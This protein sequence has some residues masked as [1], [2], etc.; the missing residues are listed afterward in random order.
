MIFEK[1]KIQIET[2]SEYLHSVRENLGLPLEEVGKKTGIKL[3]FLQSLESGDFKVLPAEVYVYGFLRQLSQLYS[4]RSQELIDQYKKEKGIEH[5]RVK[6]ALESRT[7]FKKYFGKLVVTPK[8]LTLVLGLVFVAATAGYI[9][10]QVWSI[11]KTPSLQ[12]FEPANNQAVQASS[13]VVRGQ[14]DPG[15]AVTVNGQNIFVDN[16]GGFKTQLALS[17]GPEEITIMAQNH[18]GKSASQTINIIGSASSQATSTPVVLKVDFT[19]PVVLGFII[20]DQPAQTLSFGN[21]DSKTFSASRRILLSTSD[22][23]ATKVTLNGQAL[24]AMGKA[25][26]SLTD[27]PFFAP[28]N[29]A[30]N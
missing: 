17:Q 1:K 30:P 20:D 8:I 15:M 5:Q 14:T 23:G 6:Q 2:L 24:G 28:P 10:W 16:G 26:E 12:I 3:K 21:G 7:W 27:I 4:V 13:V 19:A 18:F 11:N 25:K 22:A 9:I 29:S